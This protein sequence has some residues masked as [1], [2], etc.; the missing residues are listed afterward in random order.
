MVG[1]KYVLFWYVAEVAVVDPHVPLTLP[2]PPR[3]RLPTFRFKPAPTLAVAA[4]VGAM[5]RLPPTE[6]PV[7]MV[8]APLPEKIR[9]P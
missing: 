1:A 9:L 6:V 8:F 7:A 3:A 2:S 5:L 4:P